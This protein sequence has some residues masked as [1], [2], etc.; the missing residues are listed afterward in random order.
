M[1]LLEWVMSLQFAHLTL[2]RLFSLNFPSLFQQNLLG[3]GVGNKKDRGKTVNTVIL[4]FL[5]RFRSVPS[6]SLIVT[7][8]FL[9]VPTPFWAKKRQIQI[10]VTVN[11]TFNTFNTLHISQNILVE[12]KNDFLQWN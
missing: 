10:S 4:S 3:K 12:I 7:N 1:A 11:V 8:I 6:R 5:Y 2:Y 9:T